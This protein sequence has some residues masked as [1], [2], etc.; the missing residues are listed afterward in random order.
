MVTKSVRGNQLIG[1]VQE[2]FCLVTNFV[3]QCG[4]ILL[5]E[6]AQ[7]GHGY[8]SYSIE[9]Q[10]LEDVKVKPRAGLLRISP[11]EGSP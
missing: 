5:L 8:D 6:Q 2:V 7:V 9:G 4:K 10:S 1:K 3:L 11:Q